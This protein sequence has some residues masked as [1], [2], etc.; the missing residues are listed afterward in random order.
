M[1]M[2]TP[3]ASVAVVIAFLASDIGSGAGILW[4][5]H[6]HQRADLTE[7]FQQQRNKRNVPC[8]DGHDAT[9]LADVDWDTM[10]GEDGKSHY[11]VRVDGEWREVP[12][13]ALVDGPNKEGEALLWIFHG[14]LLCFMPGAGS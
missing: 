13:D 2:P 7:W 8:C 1:I 10:R 9:K 4:L 3:F 6:D 14:Q 11:K 5:A 12:D